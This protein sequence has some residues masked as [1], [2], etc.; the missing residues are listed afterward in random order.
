MHLGAV[1]FAHVLLGNKSASV[2]LEFYLPGKGFA[3][4][5][6]EV[7]PSRIRSLTEACDDLLDQL[8]RIAISQV[9]QRIRKKELVEGQFELDCEARPWSGDFTDTP[10]EGPSTPSASLELARAATKM[11]RMARVRLRHIKR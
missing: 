1:P 7:P 2:E 10:Y 3:R 9:L 8:S 5:H 4:V 6:A 11:R